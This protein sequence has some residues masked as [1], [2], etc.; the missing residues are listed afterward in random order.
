MSHLHFADFARTRARV[1][2][3]L[4]SKKLVFDQPFGDGRAI[5]CDEGLRMPAREVMGG[6]GKKFLARAAFPQQQYRGV[7][8][9]HAL[10]LQCGGLHGGVFAHDAGEAEARGVLFTKKQIFAEQLL[11]ARGAGHQ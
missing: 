4:V 3:A 2:A 7:G 9:G 6:E 8:G 1:G 5:Q 11:L 10:D